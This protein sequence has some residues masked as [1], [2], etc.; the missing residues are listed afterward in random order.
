ME[1][2]QLTGQNVLDYLKTLSP[3]QLSKP[4]LVY[5]TQQVWY[6]PYYSNRSHRGNP[7]EPKTC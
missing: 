2:E 3:E 6:T 1:A 4:F 5:D 7:S